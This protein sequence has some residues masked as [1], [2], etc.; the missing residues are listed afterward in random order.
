MTLS[1]AERPRRYRRRRR[2][3]AAKTAYRTPKDRRSRGPRLHDAIATI[4]A[5]REEYRDGRQARP[6]TLE[7]TA[8]A[9]LLDQVLEALDDLDL[10]SLAEL[11]LPR[12]FGRDG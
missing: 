9:E 10:D 8:T 4:L 11:K 5:I 1:N 2:A 12:G 7:T 6:E 3:G